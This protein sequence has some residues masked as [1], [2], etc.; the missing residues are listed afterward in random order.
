MFGPVVKPE[1]VTRR[2]NFPGNFQNF[3]SQK[4]H[5]VFIF[6]YVR[7]DIYSEIST[8]KH[9]PKR[10]RAKFTKLQVKLNCQAMSTIKVDDKSCSTLTL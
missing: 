7:H 1:L 8:T 4:S 9:Y 3:L 5:F 10:P 6:K 2:R